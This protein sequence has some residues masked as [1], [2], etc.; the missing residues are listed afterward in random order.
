MHVLDE[1]VAGTGKKEL[2]VH[3][4]RNRL[5][6]LLDRSAG[7]SSPSEIEIVFG[8]P[9]ERISRVAVEYRADLI[10]LSVHAAGVSTAH[11]RER[12]AY[13]I[14]R[15]SPCPVLTIH[16]SSESSAGSTAS[17]KD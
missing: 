14:I 6:E 13:R 12:T 10:V 11:E 15:W 1:S 3:D 4:A 9:A 7:L 2:I 8:A 5:K 17:A 16:R